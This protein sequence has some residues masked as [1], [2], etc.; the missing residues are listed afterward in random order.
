MKEPNGDPIEDLRRLASDLEDAYPAG[1][2]EARVASLLDRA[3]R[4]P[5]RRRLV[6]AFAAFALLA[7]NLGLAALADPA[8]PGD[9]LYPVDRAYEA[10]GRSLGVLESTADER[11]EEAERLVV[12]GRGSDAL[13]TVIELLEQLPS[14]DPTTVEEARRALED[15]AAETSPEAF[16]ETLD[17]LLEMV[18]RNPGEVSGREVAAKAKE[19]GE[20]VKANPPGRS[21]DRG[22]PDDVG[23]PD[24][25]PGQS[26]RP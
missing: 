16:S 1:R 12:E 15:V 13:P 17:E 21:Q 23:P 7:G 4:P 3:K 19:L 18:R 11:L 6:V 2:A 5:V 9:P 26:P 8:A 20:A 10:L 22:R 24:G 14:S 25:P